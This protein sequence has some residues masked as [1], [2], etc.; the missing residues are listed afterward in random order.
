MN[1][2]RTSVQFSSYGAELNQLREALRENVEEKE[3]VRRELERVR[4]E[5]QTKMKENTVITEL[6]E[7]VERLETQLREAQSQKIHEE[8]NYP[9]IE[10]QDNTVIGEFVNHV[11]ELVSG[12]CVTMSPDTEPRLSQALEGILDKHFNQLDTS[13]QAILSSN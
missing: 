9:L 2:A 10:L 5:Q 6:Q 1:L 12:E 3:G 7:R 11:D 8:D 13:L 4:Q